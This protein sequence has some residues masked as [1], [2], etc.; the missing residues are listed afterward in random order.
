MPR[1]VAINKY[2]NAFKIA[3]SLSP[4]LAWWFHTIRDLGST[5]MSITSY[6]RWL[7]KHQPLNRHFK[8]PEKKREQR[9]VC[10]RPSYYSMVRNQR[11][12]KKMLLRAEIG[13]KPVLTQLES[14]TSGHREMWRAKSALEFC[15]PLF[16]RKSTGLF[17]LQLQTLSRRWQ[18]ASFSF[19]IIPK[20]NSSNSIV[21]KWLLLRHFQDFS[22]SSYWGIFISSP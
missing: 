3:L 4:G 16:K 2:I 12:D 21:L 13:E 5:S 7:L 17:S 15:F 9:A 1:G 8:Q 11:W 6:S 10:W 19:Q 14:G 18:K 22:N 20:A